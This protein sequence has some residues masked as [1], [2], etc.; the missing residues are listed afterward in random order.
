MYADIGIL[1]DNPVLD[2][3]F[4]RHENLA[5]KAKRRYHRLGRFAIALIAFSSIYTLAEALI[6]PT[7]AIDGIISAATLALAGVGIVLQLYLIYTHQKEVWLVNRYAVERLRS[8]K[9]QSFH[10]AHIADTKDTLIFAAKDYVTKSVTRLENELNAGEAVIRSF[11]P[12]LAV[13]IPPTQTRPA[14]P[15][16][17]KIASDAF[18]ELRVAYQKRFAQSELSQYANRR[19]VFNSSQDMI[20]LFAAAF[21]FISLGAKLLGQFDVQINTGWFDFFAVALFILGATKSI[22]DNASIEEQS[23]TRFEQYI[24][25][26]DQITAD[27]GKTPHLPTLVTEMELLCMQELDNFCRAAER[28]SYRM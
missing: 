24:R 16:L 22:L 27:S 23:E 1:I 4:V 2:E 13:N 19:R 5:V 21:A 20:Y 25:D 28:I 6:L 11:Q 14:N 17:A 18:L 12:V 7:Y 3:A 8:L 10:L 9:F 15:E 26:I